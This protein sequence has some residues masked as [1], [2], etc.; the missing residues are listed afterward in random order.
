[1]SE[2][3]KW[4]VPFFMIDL[5]NFQLITTATIPQG[6][7][8]D[9]KQIVISE[10]PIPGRNFQ[11]IST[12]GG[13]NRKISFTLP[14]VKRNDIYGNLLMLKQFDGLRNQA[15]G[16]GGYLTLSGGIKPNPQVLF[17]WGTGSVPLVW[18]VTKCDFTHTA[19]MMNA[20]AYPQHTLIDMELVLDEE[21]LLYK[22]EEHGTQHADPRK[23][24]RHPCRRAGA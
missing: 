14:I 23:K 6:D 3:G 4:S 9:S 11:P 20:A 2:A 24:M 5:S 21:N 15:T 19:G 10:T 8:K 13:G 16:F 12:G 7:I 18:Y 1:M 22:G 17:Y